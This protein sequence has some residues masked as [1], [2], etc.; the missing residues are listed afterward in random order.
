[1]PARTRD[2]SFGIEIPKRVVAVVLIA[3]LINLAI[4]QNGLAQRSGEWEPDN[5]YK[6]T[7]VKILLI[8]MAVAGATAGIIYASVK[9]GPKKPKLPDLTITPSNA[10][11]KNVHVGQEAQ[12][13]VTIS[14]PGN[15]PILLQRISVSGDSFSINSSMQAPFSLSPGG[16]VKVVL[17]FEP[18]SARKYSGRLEIGISNPTNS[19]TRIKRSSIRGKGI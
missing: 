1:M 3:A 8:G 13:V 2:T 9:R 14:N 6:W 19:G 17:K 10:D 5:P 4:P 18:T 15:A 7:G 12:E 11:F 16:S